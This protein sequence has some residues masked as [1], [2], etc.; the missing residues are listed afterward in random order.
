M[1]RFAAD[2]PNQR[3]VVKDSWEYMARLEDLLPKEVTGAGIIN[4]VH[5]QYD[6]AVHI[7][8]WMDSICNN[9]CRGLSV[10]TSWNIP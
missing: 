5:Y 8:G 1:E 4:V 9:V 6:E 10:M 2:K 3:L 7:G